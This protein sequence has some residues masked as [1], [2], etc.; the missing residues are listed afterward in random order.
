MSPKGHY[1][2]CIEETIALDVMNVTTLCETMKNHK[3]H[4]NYQT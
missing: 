1:V 2:N 3:N 4:K